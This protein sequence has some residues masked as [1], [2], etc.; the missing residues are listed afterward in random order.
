MTRPLTTRR[1]LAL[2]C[3]PIHVCVT[4]CPIESCISS[5]VSHLCTIA[6][7]RVSPQIPL[8]LVGPVTANRAAFHMTA[9]SPSGSVVRR[10]SRRA[11]YLVLFCMT[12]RPSQQ[13]FQGSLPGHRH[14]IPPLS[15]RPSHSI[16]SDSLTCSL[17]LPLWHLHQCTHPVL[18]RQCNIPGG[19]PRWNGGGLPGS[20]HPPAVSQ[21]IEP[22]DVAPVVFICGKQTAMK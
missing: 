1:T 19:S 13:K 12:A 5:A 14:S 11:P 18:A 16:W 7:A 17:R 9:I 8:Y 3:M 6:R 21:N 4:D 22:G 10:V 2:Q 15:H 20:R